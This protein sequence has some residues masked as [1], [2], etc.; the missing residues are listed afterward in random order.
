MGTRDRTGEKLVGTPDGVVKV[1][2][3]RRKA[4][5]EVIWKREPMEVMKGVPWE[6]VPGRAGVEI[7]SRVLMPEVPKEIPLGTR[8]M[9]EDTSWR[10]S[11]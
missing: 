11:K 3:I 1:R 8:H 5:V 2:L 9:E 10:T 6:P 4:T 7:H